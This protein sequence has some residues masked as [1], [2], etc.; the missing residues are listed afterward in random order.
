MKEK[1]GSTTGQTGTIMGFK[2]KWQKKKAWAETDVSGGVVQV[3]TDKST[4]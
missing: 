3:S 4:M 2:I 1:K